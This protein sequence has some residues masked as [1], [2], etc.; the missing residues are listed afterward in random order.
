MGWGHQTLVLENEMRIIRAINHDEGKDVGGVV[1]Y[2]FHDSF[3]FSPF[4]LPFS[5]SMFSSFD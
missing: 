4:L 3:L 2:S 5:F 1:V